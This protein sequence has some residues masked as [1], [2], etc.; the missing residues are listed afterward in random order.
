M[1]ARPDDCFHLTVEMVREIHAEALERFGGLDGIR[2]LT[3]LESAVAAPQSSFGGQ[4]PY[5]DIPEVAAAYLFYLCKNH[6]F[7]DG[8]KRAALGACLVFLRLND[9]E[10]QADGPEWEDLTM[11]IASNQLDREQATQTI[12]KLVKPMK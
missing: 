8:N 3:L 7:I 9:F 11:A 6:P 1:S 12:R 10:P 2:E 5:A 4:S